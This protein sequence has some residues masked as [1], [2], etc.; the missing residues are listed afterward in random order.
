MP[1]FANAVTGTCKQC[2]KTVPLRLNPRLVCASL[3][4]PVV[5]ANSSFQIGTVV[6]ETGCIAR[7]KLVLSDL[8]WQQLLGRTS[9]ELVDSSTELLRYLEHRLLFLRVTFVFGWSEEVGKL[10]ILQVLM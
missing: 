1:L 7:G 9:S 10:A 2:D 6:D 3:R 8:A 5:T 4:T